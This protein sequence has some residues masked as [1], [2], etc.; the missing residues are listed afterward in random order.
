VARIRTIKPDAFASYSLARVPREVRWTFAG[1]W[2]YCDD[3]GRARDD[4]RLIKAA[5][6]PLD[7][8]VTLDILTADLDALELV[9]CICRYVVGNRQ[10]LHVPRWDHQKINRPTASKIPECPFDH[11]DSVSEPDASLSA[12]GGLSEGSLAERK[13][14]E[15]GT[16]KRNARP[17]VSDLETDPHFLAFWAA[18]PR[19]TDKGH[20]KKAWTKAIG[21]VEPTVVIAAAERFATR[22]KNDDPKFIPHP[23]TWLNGERWADEETKAV[24]AYRPPEAHELEQPPDG[25]SPAEYDEWERGQRAKRARA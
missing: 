10:Y 21:S 7:D 15:Q 11:E 13:G 5:L 22:T 3:D 25:L 4:V 19:R 24:A 23:A 1:I 20:A 9:G 18:Y 17:R 12:H 14:K 6:Y 16:G 2:T 8:D